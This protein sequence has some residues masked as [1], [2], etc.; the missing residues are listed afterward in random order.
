VHIDG[1]R[2]DQRPF[3]ARAQEFVAQSVAPVAGELDGRANPEE[4]FSW[5]IVEAASRAGIRTL[6]LRRE[7]GGSEIDSLTTAL[8]LEELAKGDLGVSVVF[9]QTLKIVQTLQHACSREQALRFLPAF[10][11]DSRG[12]L[13]I[14]ITEPDTSSDYIIPAD[15]AAARFRTTAVRHDGAWIL[16]GMKHFISNG[17][18]ARLYLVFAQTNMSTSLARGSTCFLV[19]RDTPGFSIGRVHNKMGERLANN[20]ELIF[21]D[22]RLRDDQI[23]GEVDRGFAI[24]TRFFH[25]SNAYAAA[26]VLGVAEAAYQRTW[27]WTSTRI[28]G[29]K[30]LIDH[31]TTAEDLAEFRM[32]IDAARAYAHNAAYC[33]DYPELRDPTMGALP[34]VF[35]A[36]VAWQVVTRALELHG[37]YGYMRE[38]GIEKLV[39]DAAAFLHSDGANRSLLLK[40]AR[41]LRASPPEVLSGGR[42]S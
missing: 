15:H 3:V 40:A 9:A 27:H 16:N 1:I 20:A 29:G 12:L 37:G 2:P 8:V 4:C 36:R 28:Q 23:L 41:F 7:F 19:P 21:R 35:A 38:A 6:T 32:L 13:A 14:G 31:D 24:L 18:R 22:C 10:A 17:N 33:A 5:E 42:R 25:A 30:A 39:R 11:A 34:K 26:S